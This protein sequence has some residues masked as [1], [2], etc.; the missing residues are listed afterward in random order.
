MRVI[1]RNSAERAERLETDGGYVPAILT[2]LAMGALG[3]LVAALAMTALML[4]LREVLGLPTPSEMVGDRLTAFITIPQFFALLNQFG[5]YEGLKQAG[6]GGVIAGQLGVGVL[7]GVAYAGYARSSQRPWLFALA[8]VGLLWL[9]TVAFLWPNLSTNYRGLPPDYARIAALT[10]LLVA[11][12][13]YGLVLVVT[14]RFVRTRVTNDEHTLTG[15]RAFLLGGMGAI[16]AVAT[17][18]LL[19]QLAQVATF[20]YDGMEYRGEDVQPITPNDR[21]YTVTK[22]IVDPN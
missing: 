22:N 19:R 15:R 8:V 11:H 9:L 6:G 12:S 7:A 16:L 20:A 13:T 5:G 18:G 3:G 1:R 4:A 2:L 17:G 10:S 14:S 21:F